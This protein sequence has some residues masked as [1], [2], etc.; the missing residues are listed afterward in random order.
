MAMMYGASWQA[1]ASCWSKSIFRL[2]M[3]LVFQQL[4]DHLDA[5]GVIADGFA[6]VSY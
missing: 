4:G 5:F 2:V 1:A 6:D 3:K